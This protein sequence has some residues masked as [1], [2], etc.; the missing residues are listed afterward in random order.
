MH[1]TGLAC[2]KFIQKTKNTKIAKFSYL[3]VVSQRCKHYFRLVVVEVGCM[4]SWLAVNFQETLAILI[5]GLNSS[6]LARATS[7]FL[8]KLR[9]F[10]WCSCI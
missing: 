4:V 2:T 9:I 7:L 10:V 5:V 3:K 8:I 1:F 6:K